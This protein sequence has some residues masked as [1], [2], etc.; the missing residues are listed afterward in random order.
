MSQKLHIYKGSHRSLKPQ[1]VAKFVGVD[2]QVVGENP[3]KS[4]VGKLPV[5][6]TAEGNLFESN[7][8]ARYLGRQGKNNLFG[9]NA[10]E[11]ASVDQWM[12]FTQNELELPLSVVVYPFW[13]LISN[14]VAATEKAVSDI[15]K[16]LAVVEKY[17]ATRTFLVGQRVSLADITLSTHLSPFFTLYADAAFRKPFPNVTRW[18]LTV[19]NQPEYKAVTGEVKL[20]EVKATPKE[21]VVAEKPKPAPKKEEPKP[22]KKEV[23]EDD[24]EDDE[25]KE[26]KKKK[27]PLDDLPPSTFN[28]DEWKRTYSN[29][30]TKTV[31]IPYFWKNFDANGYSLWF[32]EYK[33]NDECTQVFKTANLLGGFI[34]RLD[35]LRKYGFANMIIFGDEPNLTVT[36]C[37]LVR[38]TVAPPEL[39]ECDDYEH[40][41]WRQANPA[42]E[43]DRE[44]FNDFL[45][46][47]GNFGGKKFNQAKTFK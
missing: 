29:T 42:D 2:V 13:G 17:L 7:A 26:D 12:D 11:A 43:K 36:V 38:G 47:E 27:N 40:Y 33:Y 18:F 23:E 10:F 20:C 44:L 30:D 6:E 4:L 24:G 46:W 25:E 41:N 45:A 19:V 37:F 8:I 21:V 1:I 32:G 34:Q 35:K 16:T 15:K 28:L 31:A 14:N 39:T 5:L 3:T 22:K 9:K